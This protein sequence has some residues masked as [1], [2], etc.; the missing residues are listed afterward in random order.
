MTD[1]ETQ[2][3]DRAVKASR[4]DE[5]LGVRHGSMLA[6]IIH[7]HPAETRTCCREMCSLLRRHDMTP[8]YTL[9]PARDFSPGRGRPTTAMS[10]ASQRRSDEVS[11]GKDPPDGRSRS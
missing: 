2:D 9:F 6:R 1:T 3:R 7:G 11:G 4:L 10:E 8:G 5:Q